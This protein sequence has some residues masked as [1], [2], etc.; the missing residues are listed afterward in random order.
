MKMKTVRPTLALTALLSLACGLPAAQPDAL[1]V[2]RK[3]VPPVRASE[4]DAPPPGDTVHV[5]PPTGETETDRASILAAL[6]RVRPGGTVQFAPGTY[7]VGEL[8]HVTAAGITVVGH[9]DGTILRGCDP[10]GFESKDFAVAECNGFSLT[11]GHQTVRDLTFEYTWHALILGGPA[12]QA[13]DCPPGALP[14]ESR[15]GGYLVEGNTFRESPNGI[16]VVGQWHEPAVIRAN[17]FINTYHAVMVNGMTAHILDN[18]VSVPEPERLPYT[19]H[20]GLPL[21]IS[22]WEAKGVSAC[23]RNMIVGNRIE[24]HPDGIAIL[25]FPGGSCRENVIRDNT[26]EIARVPFTSPSTAIHVRS[27]A[28]STVTGVPL[29]LLNRVFGE[30]V[31]EDNLIEGNRILGAEGLAIEILGASGNRIVDN[32]IIGV[33]PRDPFPGNTLFPKA[34]EWQAANGSGIWVSPG[35]NG[36]EIVGNTFEAVASVDV[37]LEG[38]SNRVT[39]RS[40]GDDVRDAGI[41]NIVAVGEPDAA[42][43]GGRVSDELVDRVTIYRDAYGVPHVHGETDA[44]TVFG[45]MYAQA[46]DDLRGVEGGVLLALGRRAERDG[47]EA[48]GMDLRARALEVEQHARAEYER[49]SARFRAIADAWAAGLNY[50]R[51]RHPERPASPLERFEPWHLLARGRIVAHQV[52]DYAP[53]QPV[54]AELREAATDAA[55]LRGSNMWMIGP[56]RSASGHAML[57]INPHVSVSDALLLREGHLLS[58]EGL[59][60]YGGFWPG[61]PLPP[62]GHTARHGWTV[63]VS[64]PD[65]VDLWE[66]SFDHPTDSLAYRYGNEYRSARQWT[67]T[68]RVATDSGMEER[69]VIF[70]ASHHGPIVAVRDGKPLAM[71]IARYEDGGNYQQLYAM[72]RAR[73]LG[74]FQEAV[75]QLRVLGHNLGYADRDGNVWYVYNSP[76]PRRSE[77]FDWSRPVDGSDPETEWRGY[78]TLEEL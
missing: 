18:H 30:G 9:P 59:N 34:P 42:L 70:R 50:Y 47:E 32:T 29:A 62:F 54:L 76:V 3:A 74:E 46:E 2:A 28:D 60:V 55:T 72:A 40:P 65:V 13:G 14:V 39:L 33:S 17:R 57:F 35:S 53:E 75:G 43:P 73:S 36:N 78:H 45:F 15:T 56:T 37:F 26:I 7:L 8:I 1:T 44:A 67:E 20:P 6:E 64:L 16:R 48:L 12:C 38:D 58:D 49:A 22:G 5:A 63:T 24:G 31:I 4:A 19:R 25:P 10:S 21:M 69:E 51:E 77:R 66:L 27:T 23:D 68:V 41:G 52:P 61:D 11:G 71:R